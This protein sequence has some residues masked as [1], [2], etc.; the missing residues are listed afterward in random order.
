[1]RKSLPFVT[2]TQKYKYLRRPV[3]TAQDLN[4]ESSTVSQNSTERDRSK[5]KQCQ[6]A[7][8]KVFAGAG[9]ILR[10]VQENKC[11]EQLRKGQKGIKQTDAKGPSQIS[12]QLL[13]LP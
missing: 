2:A 6:L 7:T 4:E 1:M 9:M 5:G 10:R 11:P 3:R 8:K 13:K 12:G